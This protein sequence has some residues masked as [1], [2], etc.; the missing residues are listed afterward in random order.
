MYIS[1][2]DSGGVG[3]KNL[4]GIRRSIHIQQYKTGDMSTCFPEHD[5]F[6]ASLLVTYG[7]GSETQNMLFSAH[8]RNFKFSLLYVPNRIHQ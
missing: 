3:I 5:A 7:E 1:S 8:Q 6:G 4:E 2:G